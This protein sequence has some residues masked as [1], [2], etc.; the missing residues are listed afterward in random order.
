M[1]AGTLDAAAQ[2]LSAALQGSATSSGVA[3]NNNAGQLAPGLMTGSSA[4]G[5][6][7]YQ[8]NIA[9]VVPALAA[10]FVVNAKQG[11]LRNAIRE[12]I[13]QA[14][15]GYD[16]AKSG[17]QARQRTFQQKQAQKARERQAEDDRRYAASVAAQNALSRGAGGYGV[18]GVDVSGSGGGPTMVA[19][20][21]KNGAAGYAFTDAS[22][23]PISAS[24]YA[25]QK[26][27]SFTN[28]LNLM[29]QSGDRGAARVMTQSD[30]SSEYANYYRALTWQ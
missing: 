14:Q 1:D 16:S 11:A 9:P 17:Y 6:R 25:R 27:I 8:A 20:N 5:G 10:Q 3:I 24:T 21:G 30:N 22:G 15:L 12:S 29:A 7:N 26:G 13:N 2:A 4:P 23:K 18:A 28:L 19:K